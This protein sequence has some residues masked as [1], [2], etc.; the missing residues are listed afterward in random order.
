MKTIWKSPLARRA[1]STFV[2]REELPKLVLETFAKL[3]TDIILG[4]QQSQT[5]NVVVPA[6]AR[7]FPAKPV[8]PRG[9]NSGQAARPNPKSKR[10]CGHVN[11]MRACPTCA[12]SK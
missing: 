6:A 10:A 3:V 8:L 2:T 1:A 11:K 4:A 12:S 5:V 9:N 7:V